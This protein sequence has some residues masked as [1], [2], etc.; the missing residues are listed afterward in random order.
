[1]HEGNIAPG[2]AEGEL[3]IVMR[4]ATYGLDAKALEP[5]T[6]YSSVSIDGGRTWSP[7]QPEPELH[8]TVSKAYFG[9]DAPGN[10]L[11]AYST[12]PAWQRR[13]F[14]Y[15]VRRP[16]GGWSEERIFYDAGVR[17]S[18][19]TLLEHAPGRFYAVWDSSDSPD[20]PRTAIR[21]GRFDIG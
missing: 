13:T 4:T 12:G 3:K 2:D 6:A 11:Y 1:M 5:P 21:F 18:Y 9:Q 7:G 14:A 20:M 17:N 19:P 16:G 8:N 15:K 10:Y